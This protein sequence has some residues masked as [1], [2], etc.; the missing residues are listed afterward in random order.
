MKTSVSK[1]PIFSFDASHILSAAAAE[2][3]QST[4]SPKHSSRRL[5]KQRMPESSSTTKTVRLQ[6]AGWLPIA[7]A[8]RVF[9]MGR[10]AQTVPS[11]A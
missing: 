7:G 6:S 11:G 5:T 10:L 1:R 4:V 3:A 9:T 8:K 2:S